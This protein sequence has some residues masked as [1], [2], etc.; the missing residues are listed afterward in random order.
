VSYRYD[1]QEILGLRLRAS[2]GLKRLSRREF[3]SR[4]Q[5]LQVVSPL[6]DS[7]YE[8]VMRRE[9]R[10]KLNDSPH[11]H[12]WHV[13]FHASQFPGDDP[14]ACPRQAMYRMMDLP[15]GGPTSRWLNN[16]AVVGKAL[17]V[18]LVSVFHSAGI[19]ISAPPDAEVQT[20]FE[21]PELMLTGSVDSA[22]AMRKRATPIEI[23][24]K[25]ENTVAKMRLGLVGPDQPHVN[26]LKT[27]M[28]LIR[29]AQEAGEM[30][31]DLKVCTNGY[32]YYMP[33]DTG[34][35][36]MMAGRV[37]TAEFLVE[38][39]PVWYETGL[40]V[41]KEWVGYWEEEVLVTSSKATKRHPLG[42]RWSYPPCQFCSYKKVCQEDH[43]EG[44]EGLAESNGITFAREVN[45]E[46]DYEA[47]RERV[48]KRWEKRRKVAA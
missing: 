33:R 6:A 30:W 4:L 42:W 38:Y 45:P 7:S 13:S 44:V 14:F 40:K 43:K 8:R 31:T 46:Y 15:S 37:P 22:V 34:F 39:D 12:P 5:L 41:L 19:L 2:T 23:K 36:P 25:H 29:N 26:Q 21:I 32:V 17:E 24:T 47:A 18:D 1:R 11:G 10:D 9:W 28:G 27:Q 35:D 3:F 16:T 48:K 20:G